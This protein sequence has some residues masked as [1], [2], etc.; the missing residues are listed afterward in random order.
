[1]YSEMIMGFHEYTYHGRK[2][3]MQAMNT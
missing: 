2:C 1:M 3:I